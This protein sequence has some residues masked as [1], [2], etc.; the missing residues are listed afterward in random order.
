MFHLMMAS[1]EYQLSSASQERVDEALP[2]SAR[3]WEKSP[4][5]NE[6]HVMR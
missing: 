3:T 6:H 1:I 2:A 5:N 4:Q